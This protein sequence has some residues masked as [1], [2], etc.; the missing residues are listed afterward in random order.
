MK[1]ATTGHGTIAKRMENAGLS[2]EVLNVTQIATF[3]LT[4]GPYV[5]VAQF[6]GRVFVGFYSSRGQARFARNEARRLKGVTNTRVI[7]VYPYAED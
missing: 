7:H 6:D 3:V 4:G 1:T 2:Y 5:A